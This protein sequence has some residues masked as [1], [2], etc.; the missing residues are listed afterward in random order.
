MSTA[1][2]SAS[3][4]SAGSWACRRPPTT[5]AP[6]AQRS[7]RAVEDERLLDADRGLHAANY[8]AYGYRRIWKALRRAGEHGRPRPGQAADA[9]ARHPGRQAPRQAVAHHDRRPRGTRGRRTSSSATSRAERPDRAV[10][11]RLHLPALLG[12][13]GVLQLRHRRLQPPDRRLAVR[14]PHA[15]RLVLDA[16][17]MALTRRQAGADVELVHHSDAGSQYPA[18]PS[19]RSSTT[20]ACWPRSARSATPTTTRWPR[21]SSTPSRP[22]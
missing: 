13:R 14:R 3:S 19:P 4:R 1:A 6:A 2:A 9:H 21:A 10:G 15:H 11:R 18:T 16:L 5:S 17:R 12:G 7:A 22:S 8:Y 20:T